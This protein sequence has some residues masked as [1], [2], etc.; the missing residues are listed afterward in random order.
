MFC[1]AE[2]TKNRER[3][4]ITAQQLLVMTKKG[5]AA[6]QSAKNK[7]PWEEWVQS[8]VV[9]TNRVEWWFFLLLFSTEEE[10]ADETKNEKQK[11]KKELTTYQS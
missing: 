1:R 4:P 10:E 8:G 9:R 11:T 2:S 6:A 5:S 3:R 7:A